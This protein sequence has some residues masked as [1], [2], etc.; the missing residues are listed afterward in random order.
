MKDYK[1][2]VKDALLWFVFISLITLVWIGIENL[3]I[4]ILL[5]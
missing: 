1:L 4:H 5:S 3:V 2:T